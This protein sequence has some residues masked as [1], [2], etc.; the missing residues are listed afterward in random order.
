MY[1]WSTAI[2]N[3]G[4]NFQVRSKRVLDVRFE[5]SVRNKIHVRGISHTGRQV[6][7]LCQIE[8]S[9]KCPGAIG[10]ISGLQKHCRNQCQF[11]SRELCSRISIVG[12]SNCHVPPMHQTRE[13]HQV[14]PSIAISPEAAVAEHI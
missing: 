7:F 9:K 8:W 1:F 4:H 12:S 3:S 5:G 10:D 11:I 14:D 13:I 6:T 2:G